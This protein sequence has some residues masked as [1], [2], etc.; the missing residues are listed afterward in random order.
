MVV[1]YS[2]HCIENMY[3]II[4]AQVNMSFVV[5]FYILRL[6]SRIRINLTAEGL[7]IENPTK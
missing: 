6:T 4:H 3:Q 5:Y 7:K 2:S 1:F